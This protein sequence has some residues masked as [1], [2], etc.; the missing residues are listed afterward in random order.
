MKLFKALFTLT[1]LALCSQ[2]LQTRLLDLF[3][4]QS[5]SW[6]PVSTIPLFIHDLRHHWIE[7]NIAWLERRPYPTN[8]LCVAN[9]ALRN[10][11]IHGRAVPADLFDRLNIDNNRAGIER[12][13]WVNMRDRLKEISKCP[14]ALQQ[15]TYLY[16]DVY[17]DE[18]PMDP[19]EKSIQLLADVLSAMPNLKRIKW[20]IPAKANKFF[21]KVF[22][23]Q[24]LQ[25]P[26]ITHLVV[27]AF[28]QHMVSICPNL[29]RLEGGK[30]NHH[31]SWSDGPWGR[32]NNPE[33]LL[34]QEASRVPTITSL[35]FQ[36]RRQKWNRQLVRGKTAR[37][38]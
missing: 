18:W 27:G 25:L 11:K 13:G 3:E 30:Y 16:I 10:G 2:A 6:F 1:P 34:L 29:E 31:W 26:S 36:D 32:E 22:A 21:E 19:G 17:D 38:S 23:Q 4:L 14:V 35:S 8:D 33:K 12:K 5:P 28:A 24:S 37:A 9:S 15:V 7:E 20:G